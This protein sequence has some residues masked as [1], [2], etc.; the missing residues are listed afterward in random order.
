MDQESTYFDSFSIGINYWVSVQE[1]IINFHPTMEIS[2]LRTIVKF[3]SHIQSMWTM[4]PV[5]SP[6]VVASKD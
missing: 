2:R 1:V 4:T 5:M 3:P 6:E